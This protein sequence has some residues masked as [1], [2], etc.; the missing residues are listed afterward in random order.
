MANSIPRRLASID[1]FRAVTMFLMIFVNDLWSLK[2]IPAWLEH[3]TKNE[4]GMGLADTVFPAFLFIVGLS[5]PFA[6]MAHRAKGDSQKKILTYI[7][8]RSFALL[9]M[10]VFHV[11]LEEY[12]K[13]DS[14]LPK[15]I[16]QILITLG[17]F[18]I[19]LDYS[20]AMQK[21]KKQILQGSGILL[22][23]VM[24]LLYKGGDPGHAIWMRPH[25]WG[26]LGLI[27]WAYLL[28]AVIYLFSKQNLIVITAA[29]IFFLWFNVGVNAGWLDPIEHFKRYIWISGDGSMPALTMTGVLIA[30]IYI[31]LRDSNKTSQCWWIFSGIALIMLA[32]GFYYRPQ[33]GISKIRATPSW[34]L[35][36]AGISIFC[37]LFFIFLIDIK[38][39]QKWFAIIKPAGTSTLT[40]YLLPY[41]HYAILNML[42]VGFALPLFLRTGGVGIVKS[43]LYALIIIIITGML[44]RK[45]IRLKI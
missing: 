43:L 28:G 1:I 23:A 15:P 21:T 42:G 14:I 36:C 16:W 34:V 10:G 11:N 8:T 39:K 41:F 38:N 18:L 7:L 40:A 19:W 17:F 45:R 27:G 5:I 31:K 2:N 6:I 3:T 22:L 35:I 20:P 37:F 32:A 30:V 9:L 4:D 44:E 33:W 24:A 12:N 26:I 25:W 13:Y 29:L